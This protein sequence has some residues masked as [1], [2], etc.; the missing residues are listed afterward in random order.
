MSGMNSH[1][2]FDFFFR[3]TFSAFNFWWIFLEMKA[4]IILIKT[5]AR[6]D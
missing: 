5:A 2:I 4:V 1:V 3:Q 6:R